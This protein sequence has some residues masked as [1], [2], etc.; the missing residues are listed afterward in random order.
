VN[1][2]VFLR[3]ASQAKEVNELAPEQ[4]EADAPEQ[5]R[6][7]VQCAVRPCAERVT[8][9]T[10]KGTAVQPSPLALAS[11]GLHVF[12][13]CGI[14]AHRQRVVSPVCQRRTAGGGR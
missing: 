13:W 1:V 10:K 4:K 9:Y 2:Q 11:S 8:L 6:M 12:C 3:L 5:R 7:C 14:G